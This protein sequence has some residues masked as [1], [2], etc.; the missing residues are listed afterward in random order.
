[1]KLRLYSIIILSV[2]TLAVP[3]VFLRGTL[4]QQTAT[5]VDGLSR[6]ASIE[7]VSVGPT[8]WKDSFNNITQWTLPAS[9]I[10]AILQ[11]NN[12]LKL[13]VAFPSKSN[14]QSLSIYRN[15]NLC[16]VREPQPTHL[17]LAE[18]SRA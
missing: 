6:L 11:V 13:T 8:I 3:T 18:T 10:P 7:G 14:P 9:S 5:E 17:K 15:V 1:M 16:L 4:P 2:L 12:S